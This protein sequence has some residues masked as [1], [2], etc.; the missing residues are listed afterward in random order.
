MAEMKT[1]SSYP[2]R[3]NTTPFNLANPTCRR[4]NPHSQKHSAGNVNAVQFNVGASG[5]LPIPCHQGAVAPR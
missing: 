5:T 2:D 1:E 3:L 4:Y